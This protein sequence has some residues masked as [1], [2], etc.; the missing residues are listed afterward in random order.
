[1]STLSFLIFWNFFGKTLLNYLKN[2]TRG[3]SMKIYTGFGDKG[4]TRLFGGDVVD[5]DHLRIQ[6]YG[7]LDELNSVIGVALTFEP[8]ELLE[9]QLIGIQKD[10]FRL[11]A[12]LAAP[13][14]KSRNQLGKSVD[15]DDVK[16]LEN[17]IDTLDEQLTPLQNFVLPG[18]SRFAAYLHLARTTCRRA[19][20]YLVTLSKTV[21]VDQ[22]IE[23]YLNRLSDLFFVM[24]RFANKQAQVSDIL[25]LNS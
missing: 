25:W 19:E 23:I 18:G 24:A 14:E 8:D 17:W 13:D 3:V 15:R 5:K 20:R 1:V 22:H 2:L 9:K 12:I 11:S 16:K 10:I 7:T 4:R 21:H 6:V